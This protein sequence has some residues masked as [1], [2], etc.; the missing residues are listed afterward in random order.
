M[1]SIL[2]Q[3][4]SITSTTRTHDCG[5]TILIGGYGDYRYCDRCRAFRYQTA[6]D[7]LPTGSDR[8]AN[9]AAWDRA[10]AESPDAVAR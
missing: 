9:Q 10:D 5:G 7:G 4:S 2:D 6:G 3:N 8:A 1:T